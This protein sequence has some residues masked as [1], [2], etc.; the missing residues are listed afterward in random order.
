MKW[1]GYR[2]AKDKMVKYTECV[3]KVQEEY[4]EYIVIRRVRRNYI[5][6][7]FIDEVADFRREMLALATTKDEKMVC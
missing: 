4:R 3:K 7:M 6:N 5:L 1:S 2:L